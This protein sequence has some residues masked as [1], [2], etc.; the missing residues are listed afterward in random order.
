MK[1]IITLIFYLCKMYVNKYVSVNFPVNMPVNYFI[2]L[3]D[4]VLKMLRKTRKGPV[5]EPEEP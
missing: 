3:E 4:H 5:T 2:I 1:V